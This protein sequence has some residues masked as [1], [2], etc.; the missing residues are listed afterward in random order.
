MTIVGSTLISSVDRE[1]STSL[2]WF[3]HLTEALC[4]QEAN[5]LSVVTVSSEETYLQIHI[6]LFLCLFLH[7]L[8]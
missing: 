8:N 2:N 6:Q 4:Q 1:H 5:E 7:G 3:L